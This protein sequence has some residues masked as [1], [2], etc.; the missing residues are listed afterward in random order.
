MQDV[1]ELANNI[2]NKITKPVKQCKMS[3]SQDV[4]F[5]NRGKSRVNERE[6]DEHEP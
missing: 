6:A 1:R 2:Y 4:F 3:Q 5:K